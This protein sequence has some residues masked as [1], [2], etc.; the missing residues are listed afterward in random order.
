MDDLVLFVAV[1]VVALGL[2]EIDELGLVVLMTEVDFEFLVVVVCIE[3]D[4]RICCSIPLFWAA[5]AVSVTV[6]VVVIVMVI[7]VVV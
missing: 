3:V 4:L 2:V 5:E 7:V 1:D 6:I